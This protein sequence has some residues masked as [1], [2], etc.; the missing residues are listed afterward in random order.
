MIQST[1]RPLQ[2]GMMGGA[3]PLMGGMPF[4][5]LAGGADLPMGPGDLSGLSSEALLGGIGN[6]GD[7]GALMQALGGQQLDP[8]QLQIMQLQQQIDQTQGA[9][10]Q[11][12]ATGNRPLA[13]QLQQQLQ[14]L[15]QQLQQ[16]MAGD[17]V[18]QQP[19]GGGDPG[20]GPPA[21]GGGG[22]VGTVGGASEGAPVASVAPGG[23]VAK[24]QGEGNQAAVDYA[25]QFLDRDSYTLKG[26]MD[27]FTAAG[28]KTNNCADFVSSALESTGGLKGHYVG[29][30][31]LE[32]ALIAQGYHRV[33]GADA[34]PGDV[35][36]NTSRGHTE[37]VGSQGAQTL[38]GSNNIRPGFQRISEHPND[39]NKGVYYH[40]DEP[41]KTSSPAKSSTPTTS[42]K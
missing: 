36:M 10:Q 12:Q 24:P 22:P 2:T 5:G 15:Q 16:L 23:S 38:I 9:L 29:V 26:V 19:G 14:Q 6:G 41:S 39:P 31:A 17:S 13:E 4:G 21:G 8:K 3:N 20:G 35:W 28:G 37:L 27:N 18:Q 25:R 42:K 33:S 34:Q 30:K 1:F 32:Q 11:A 40:R 7:L